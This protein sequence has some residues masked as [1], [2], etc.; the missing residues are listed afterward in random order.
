[1]VDYSHNICDPI[2]PVSISCRANH[3]CSSQDSQLLK[4][5]NCFPTHSIIRTFQCNEIQRVC[6]K[7]SDQQ[8]LNFFMFCELQDAVFIN[9]FLLP[10]SG[11][12]PIEFVI[13]SNALSLWNLT[14]QT[15]LTE[16]TTFCFSVSEFLFELL[17]FLVQC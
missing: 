8:H 5:D 12:Q 13:A 10:S 4:T 17:N 6:M 2:A 9:S 14:S 15:Y 1:M 3:Y 11:E 7:L 16:V